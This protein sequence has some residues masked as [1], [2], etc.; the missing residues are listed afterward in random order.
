MTHSAVEFQQVDILFTRAQG[1]KGRA[2]LRSALESLDAG[3]TRARIAEQF[4]VVLG[5]AD[6]NL[7]VES[8]HICVLM[9]LSGSG[10]STLLRAANGLNRV[11]RGRVLV[12]DGDGTADVATCTPGKLRQ[13][14]RERI[15]MVFQQFGLL[16]WRTVRD[17]VGL[18]L[19][20]RGEPAG[21]RAQI[22]DE[23]LELVGLSQWADRYV[24]ELSG[25]MQQRV[26]LARAF[27]TD[28]DI[29]LMDEPFSALDPL[30]RT[31]LQDELLALQARVKK[32]ILFVSHDLDEALRLGNQISVLEGGRILQTGSVQDIVLH[33]AHARVA[34]FVQHMNPL[35]VLSGDMIMRTR[36]DM[37][38]AVAGGAPGI[39]V[40]AAGRYV[41]RL[42]AAGH[43][44]SA[45][46]NGEPLPIVPLAEAAGQ[47]MAPGMRL[48]P[49]TTALQQ[50]VELCAR[51]GHP[52]LLQED[53]RL[54]G[55]CGEAEILRALAG[56]FGATVV[57]GSAG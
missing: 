28:A 42:D 57:P 14:R 22:V 17:N 1:R 23:K 27:A 43:P 3:A 30:I 46:M 15:A 40:D 52:V 4:G 33:P 9:G 51:S 50:I 35:Q 21:R 24:S 37:A 48:A 54:C 36:A 44:E 55:A 2:S 31:K 16:P 39:Q 6:A 45:R 34:E 11:T 19:E 56:S 20:L 18:G 26:G 7:R 12:R 10:K 13:L 49:A 53:G 25:G 5:V 41:V 8:G 47:P 32:T 29:L 38:P